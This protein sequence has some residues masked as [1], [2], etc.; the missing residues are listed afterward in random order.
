MSVSRA[1]WGRAFDP[2]RLALLELRMW[3][4][5]YRRQPARLFALLVEANR[6]QAGVSW[7]RA[8]VAAGLLARAAAAFGRT[9]WSAPED[10]SLRDDLAYLRDIARGYR[11]LGLPDGVDANEVA[12]RELRWWTARRSIGLSSGHAAGTAIAEL[13]SELYGLPVSAVSEAGRLRGQA[14]EFRDR[15]AAVDAA[16][17]RGSGSAYWP[18][19][20][21][22]LRASYRSLKAAVAPEWS[23]AAQLDATPIEERNGRH[24]R[25]GWWHRR[26]RP[27]RG[28]P[29][30]YAF[31]TT[32]L[33]PGTPD[34]VSAILADATALPRWWPAVYLSASVLERG[35]QHGIG[36][37]VELHTKG[38]LPYTL[39]WRFIVTESDPPR[40]F[41]IRATGDFRGQGI[42]TLT[43]EADAVIPRRTGSRRAAATVSTPMTRVVYDW[44]V[45]VEKPLLKRLSFLL[46]PIFAANHRWAMG[47][48]AASLRLE[49]ARRRAAGDP[50]LLAAIPKPPGPTFRLDGL[51]SLVRRRRWQGWR[52]PDAS[53]KS[54]VGI[55]PVEI[56]VP[57]SVA[58]GTVGA[59]AK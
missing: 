52:G 2:D 58:D 16:G 39:T 45:S 46:K 37:V 11:I 49:L 30:E 36:S 56:A 20:G 19:V 34:E 42:W 4:A 26:L 54:A 43:P 48:G 17:S 18:E 22:I 6:E 3:K 51:R 57:V 41:T 33:V 14:A 1:N 29:D 9:G 31:L 12:R 59:P 27:R 7:P 53:A 35:D 25:G 55:V 21:R 24:A 23:R 5:Y 13:Y 44:R 40:G 47:R 28:R 50:A 8:V 32:W 10:P 38:W 15:G